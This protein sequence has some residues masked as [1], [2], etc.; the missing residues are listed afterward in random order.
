VAAVRA[1]CG[2]VSASQGRDTIFI[3]TSL[4]LSHGVDDMRGGRT[5][6][7]KISVGV[8]GR[9]NTNFVTVAVDP[10]SHYNWDTYLSQLQ[11][12]LRKK[13]GWRRAKAI[14]DYRPSSNEWW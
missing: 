7:L 3:P 5:T 4:Y 9:G 10:H 12:K 8:L 1:V 13:F 2:Y 11:T 6:V 14:P